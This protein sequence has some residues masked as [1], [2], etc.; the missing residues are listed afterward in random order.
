M[1]ES[2]KILVVI[3]AFNEQETIAQV[4]D[5]VRQETNLEIL[6][7]SDGSS[8]ATARIARNNHAHV[9]E[10]CIN[11]GVGGALRAGFAYAVQNGFDAIIQIDADD[12]HPTH[13]IK[14]LIGF[15]SEPQADLVL[16]SRFVHGDDQQMKV[17]R[18]RR[19]VMH[20]LSRSASRACRTRITDASSG[21]RLIRG[22]LL[23]E[24]SR[25]FPANYLGDTY[26]ALLAAGKAGY[27]VREVPVVMRE[28][29]VGQSTSSFGQSI[30]FTLKC[31]GVATLG[32]YP[33]IKNKV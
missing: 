3:P 30:L 6:V 22:D 17:S 7:V 28:R 12:Q 2:E 20:I 31:L 11:L 9:L 13:E 8:D 1:S 14:N 25:N 10:L 19:F 32:L 4:I 29:R 21:F 24:F 18:H 15:S 16:G 23:V 33:R 27:V 5:Q 26:E